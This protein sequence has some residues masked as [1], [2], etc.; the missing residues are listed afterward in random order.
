M[1]KPSLH[2]GG[3]ILWATSYAILSFLVPELNIMI[4]L[5]RS[6]YVIT[7]SAID[8]NVLLNWGRT[9]SAGIITVITLSFITNFIFGWLL[10]EITYQFHKNR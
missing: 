2:I 9:T 7:S 3:N 5:A 10:G 8:E 4:R 6:I 1:L